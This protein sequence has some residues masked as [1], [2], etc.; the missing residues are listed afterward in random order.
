LDTPAAQ[1][2]QIKRAWIVNFA[3]II[4]AGAKYG[5]TTGSEKSAAACA[6]RSLACAKNAILQLIARSILRDKRHFCG[7]LMS[8]PLW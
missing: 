3:M 8:R 2:D 4:A 7:A 1:H 5:Q 6:E